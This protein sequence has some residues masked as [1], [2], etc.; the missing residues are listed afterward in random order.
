MSEVFNY[1]KT[2]L[3]LF[4]L[5]F[6]LGIIY[7][8]INFVV[9]TLFG[10]GLLTSAFGSTGFTL[11]LTIFFIIIWILASVLVG[12]YLAQKLWRWE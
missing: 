7:T 5:S 8:G 4:V 12:G 1:I 10:I 6:L 9:F 11:Y 2:G 3:K